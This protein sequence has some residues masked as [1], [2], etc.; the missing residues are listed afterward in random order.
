MLIRIGG[1]S[2]REPKEEEKGDWL[3]PFDRYSTP[4][5]ILNDRI[6]S[7]PT[8]LT[9]IKLSKE[10]FRR[11]DEFDNVPDWIM[12]SGITKGIRISCLYITGVLR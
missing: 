11:N 9:K 1:N 4:D 2:H 5:G 6:G 8:K 3:E 7:V 12:F 10:G